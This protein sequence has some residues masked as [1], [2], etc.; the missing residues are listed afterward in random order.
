MFNGIY[1]Y[2]YKLCQIEYDLQGKNAGLIKG[3]GTLWLS[4]DSI[5]IKTDEKWYYLPGTSI[6]KMDVVADRMVIDLKNRIRIEL[7]TKNVHVL[8]ALYHYLEG[9][10][11]KRI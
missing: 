8:K 11:W 1:M 4:P 9:E 7:R 3:S 10:P 6:K 2:A 5:F